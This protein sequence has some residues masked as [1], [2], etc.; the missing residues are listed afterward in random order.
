MTIYKKRPDHLNKEQLRIYYEASASAYKG[1]NVEPPLSVVMAEE[2]LRLEE[3]G[4]GDT[5]YFIVLLEILIIR[6]GMFS[7][8]PQDFGTGTSVEYTN[9]RT[10]QNVF[11]LKRYLSDS[12]INLRVSSNP[13]FHGIPGKSNVYLVYST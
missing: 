12:G 1:E 7:P 13:A 2:L 6:A 10:Q 3:V 9:S 8:C 11:K 4:V 5:S